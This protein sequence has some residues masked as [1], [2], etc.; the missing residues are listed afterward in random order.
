[1]AA[2]WVAIKGLKSWRTA[3]A[4]NFGL[5]VFGA[6]IWANLGLLMFYYWG[7]LDDPIV[8][9]LSLPFCALLALCVA[10]GCGQ[11]RSA[12]RAAAPRW[13][14]GGAL[15]AYLTAG[16]PA[17]ASYWAMNMQATEIAWEV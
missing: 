2:T 17:N 6:A 3:A 7:N 14:I 12:W 11:V 8:S 4:T 13:A 10:W 9:R 5:I 1:L 15:F 16:L